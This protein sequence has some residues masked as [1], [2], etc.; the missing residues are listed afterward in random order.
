[1]LGPRI[2]LALA[3]GLLTQSTSVSMSAVHA[4]PVERGLLYEPSEQDAPYRQLTQRI[5]SPGGLARD[6]KVVPDDLP[7]KPHRQARSVLNRLR[8]QRRGDRAPTIAPITQEGTRREPS[9][10][11]QESL[12]SF[13]TEVRMVNLRVAVYDEDGHSHDRLQ[14]EDFE[15]FEGEE[16]QEIAVASSED[17]PFR[18][19]LLLDLSGSTRR[20]RPAMKEAA[21][22]FV[23]I[24]RPD[25]K[26][27][28]YV[29]ANNMFQVVSRFTDDRQRLLDLIEAIPELDWGSPL[30]DTL[31]LAY[32]EELWQ[33]PDGRNAIIVITDG[34]DNRIYGIGAASKVSFPELRRAAQEWKTL[35]YPIFLDPY[36][37]LP[38]PGWALK[39]RR[40]MQQLA[41]VT[42]G[43]LFVA[44]SI[45]DLDGVY[46][47]VADE[48]RSVY[49]LGYY[50]Q[51]QVFDGSWRKVEVRVK[52]PGV[53]VRA[54]AGYYA[55]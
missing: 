26:V 10:A 17:A 33:L 51:N 9:P 55:R 1:M 24:A 35:I 34:I 2:C 46:P 39:A 14:R 52:R 48:L 15:V 45:H 3:A 41:D 8:D 49:T 4:D 47:L 42:G 32:A 44:Q 27:A 12:P 7:S 50:P 20:D 43:K 23:E 18:L 36:T 22:R 25:D 29:M 30:Y 5:D 53:N 31:V 40:H 38:P 11:G 21:R 6:Q 28:V 19:A 13:R 37:V 54:R 16:A